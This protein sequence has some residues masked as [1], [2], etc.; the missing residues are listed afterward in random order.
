LALL[1]PQVLRHQALDFQ[2]GEA[3]HHLLL[4][5]L[6]LLAD[7]AVVVQELQVIL[8]E[9]EALDHQGL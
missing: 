6:Q 3:A 1:V 4:P 2:E 7:Q 5:W 9:M 8:V